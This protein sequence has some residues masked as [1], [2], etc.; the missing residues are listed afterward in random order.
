MGQAES[1]YLVNTFRGRDSSPPQLS[2]APLCKNHGEFCTG[3]Y[4]RENKD[5]L[6]EI[7]DLD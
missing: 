5:Y 3:L 1:Q 4:F 7:S 2:L 6:V